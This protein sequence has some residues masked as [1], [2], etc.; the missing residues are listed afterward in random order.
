MD[1]T[2][3]GGHGQGASHSGRHEAGSRSAG[4][5]TYVMQTRPGGGTTG[6][7][8]IPRPRSR[9]FDDF[10]PS[11]PRLRGLPRHRHRRDGDEEGDEDYDDE[12]DDNPP[13]RADNEYTTQDR[14]GTSLDMS[15]LGNVGYENDDESDTEERWLDVEVPEGV[16]NLGS[17]VLRDVHLLRKF[18]V[19]NRSGRTLEVEL[20]SSLPDEQLGFQLTN[21][22]L[23]LDEEDH[24]Q[25]FNTIN[26]IRALTLG[27]HERQTIV[28]AFL[29]DAVF[30]GGDTVHEV[31]R[32]REAN[33]RCLTRNRNL[34]LYAWHTLYR[35]TRR[36]WRGM[37]VLHTQSRATSPLPHDLSKTASSS[38]YA[39]L[40]VTVL[41][42]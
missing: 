1:A 9:D 42:P 39:V 27:P 41:V 35:V 37:A 32:E 10:P 21:E 18:D 2:R 29:P 14:S 20:G 4:D 16:L 15:D 23:Q 13:A 12:D 28:L 26:R 38:L 3:G 30:A 7:L 22:N 34:T 24:N 31:G 17:V 11:E 36:T 25:L 8:S 5:A 40:C 6:P 19:V 33:A